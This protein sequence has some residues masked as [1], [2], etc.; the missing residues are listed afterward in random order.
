RS[1]DK[2]IIPGTKNG[3]LMTH[4]LV[5]S[6]PDDIFATQ[7]AS[8]V[9]GDLTASVLPSKLVQIWVSHLVSSC[10]QCTSCKGHHGGCFCLS[11]VLTMS[12]CFCH[13]YLPELSIILPV[14]V[15]VDAGMIDYPSGCAGVLSTC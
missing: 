11:N 6:R 15:E 9:S 2:I 12:D 3:F 7:L 13:A 4:V 10:T 8:L 14:I 1:W 5:V